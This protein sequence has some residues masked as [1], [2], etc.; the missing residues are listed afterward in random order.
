[1][2]SNV[3]T[4]RSA[5]LADHLLL[6]DTAIRSKKYWGYSD[7]LVELWK[8]DLTISEEYIR[9]NIVV[10]VYANDSFIGFYALQTIDDKLIEIDHLWL[11]PNSIHRGYGK[12]IFSHILQYL[13]L[14]GYERARLVA[15]PNAST[16]YDKMGGHVIGSIQSKINGRQLKLYEYSV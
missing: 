1:M 6:T 5:E 9:T 13:K 2:E 14:H 11:L 4:Y 7:D 12:I 8:S 15:E 3:L 16:F 10:K